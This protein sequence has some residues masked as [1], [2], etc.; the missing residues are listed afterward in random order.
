VP[1]VARRVGYRAL[2][3]SRPGA[4]AG[5]E[6]WDIPRL[7]VIATTGEA[8]LA[9]WMRADPLEMRRLGAR[10]A[11]LSAGKRLLGDRAYEKLR[12]HLLRARG[13]VR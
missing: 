13:A 7:A 9:R 4:W 12:S 6:P 2:C 1:D 11:V 5:A 8:Q 3:S 10:N